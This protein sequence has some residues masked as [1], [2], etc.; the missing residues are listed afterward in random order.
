MG[1]AALHW[2]DVDGFW[3]ARRVPGLVRDPQTISQDTYAD[4]I[5]RAM[6]LGLG[7][8][9]HTDRWTVALSSHAAYGLYEDHLPDDPPQPPRPP[10]PRPPRTSRGDGVERRPLKPVRPE[11]E[12]R[13]LPTASLSVEYRF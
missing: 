10:P 6:S 11:P 1:G 4:G 7:V 8:A 3:V 9:Y 5:F 2:T 12:F 13:P